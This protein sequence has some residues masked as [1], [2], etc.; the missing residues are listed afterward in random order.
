[1]P[2]TRP[3]ISKHNEHENRAVGRL[4]KVCARVTL[5]HGFRQ[6]HWLA[7]GR[8]LIACEGFGAKPHAPV[9][10][11]KNTL[12][13]WA[14]RM[15]LHVQRAAAPVEQLLPRDLTPAYRAGKQGV[16]LMIERQMTGLLLEQP[17]RG[18]LAPGFA[19][20]IQIAI[21]RLAVCFRADRCNQNSLGQRGNRHDIAVKHLCNSA[22]PIPVQATV[23][24]SAIR[25][26]ACVAIQMPPSLSSAKL[27]GVSRGNP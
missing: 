2:R 3:A 12:D 11:P 25:I 18:P 8:T 27:F 7:V 19:K 26:G 22:G 21:S 9:P 4:L 1:M 24:G 23:P 17:R 20:K 13:Q 10:V 16:V 14:G 6:S 5:R 15:P